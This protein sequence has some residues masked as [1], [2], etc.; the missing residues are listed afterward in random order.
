MSD[1]DD[2]SIYDMFRMEAEEQVEQLQARLLGLKDGDANEA[3]LR[4]LMRGA[5]SLK[6]AAR[7]VG[8]NAAVRLTHA[9]EERFVAA[10]EGRAITQPEVDILLRSVDVLRGLAIISE[11][12]APAWSIEQEP[13][14]ATL[15]TELTGIST[16]PEAAAASKTPTPETVPVEESPASSE[17]PHPPRQATKSTPISTSASPRSASTA[18]SRC[19]RTTSSSRNPSSA[20][21]S[22]CSASSAASSAWSAPLPTPAAKAR[23][24]PK[25]KPQ[26]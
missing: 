1:L 14:I 3:A 2:L 15:V 12:E 26:P 5:H 20:Y 17:T 22:R 13:A 18:S 21:R 7:V 24:T 23:T 9:M 10:Q 19:P 4:S 16:E 8:L 25:S 11:D 6:G